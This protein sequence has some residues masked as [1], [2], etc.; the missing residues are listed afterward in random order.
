MFRF[1]LAAGTAAT[2]CVSAP[3]PAAA[4]ETILFNCFF[5][6]RHY[7]CAE[8]LPEM[9]RRIE[10][11][12]EGRVKLRV[13]PSSLAAPPEQYEAVRNG[14][15]DGAVQFNGFLREQVPGIQFGLLPFVGQAKAEASSVALWD[16]FQAHFGDS[17]PFGEAVL[18]SVFT[19]NG[20]DFYSVTDTPI[21]SVED[22]ARR[23]MWAVPGA[24]ANTIAAT[25][26]SVV[27]GP[28]VQMLE[29]VSKGV[30][31][32]HVGI[33]QSEVTQFKLTDY[34]RSVT[35][36]P[37]KIFQA[38]FSFFI[39]DAA[40]ERIDEVDRAAIMDALGGDFAR[41]MG[42]FQDRVFT[43]A[44]ED[45]KAAGVSFVEGDPAMLASLKEV[46]QAQIDAWIAA[47][48]AAG[49]DGTQVLAD[50]A[51]AYQAALGQV[52]N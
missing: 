49:V 12:T 18:L 46:G 28:A 31:D 3:A 47:V 43:A 8:F 44:H 33:P 7:V 38:S 29:I 19:Y 42:A 17:D 16:T 11:A 10:D 1:M 41:W 5:P 34:T 45:L 48:G 25:G 21:T 52:G 22:V 9:G 27:S 36:F 15:M 13:P 50:Y 14:V 37:E 6:P 51:S 20:G 32:G 24:T 4:S 30:V 26:A 39:S 35:L 23:K 2:L 40:W